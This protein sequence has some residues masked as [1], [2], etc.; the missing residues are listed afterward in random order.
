MEESIANKEL[1]A[2]I[3]RYHEKQEKETIIGVL[4]AIR[5]GMHRDG[6]WMIPV[7]PPQQAFEMLDPE[8]LKVGDTLPLKKNSISR[9]IILK[10]TM[11]KSGW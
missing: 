11:A 3:H 1:M 2:A 6:A 10:P 4:E 7:I 5:M 9:S 8:Q